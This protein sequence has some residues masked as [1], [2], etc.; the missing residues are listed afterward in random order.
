VVL[1][2]R[3]HLALSPAAAGETSLQNLVRAGAVR[4]ALAARS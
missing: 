3:A 2:A 1:P 4:L